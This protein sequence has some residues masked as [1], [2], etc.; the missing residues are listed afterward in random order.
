MAK[1]LIIQS[2]TFSESEVEQADAK[3][4]TTSEQEA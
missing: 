4:A 1:Y 3:P 2:G